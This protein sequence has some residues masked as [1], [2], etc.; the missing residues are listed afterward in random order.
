MVV[1]GRPGTMDSVRALCANPSGDSAQSDLESLLVQLDEHR[2]LCRTGHFPR[3]TD[4]P[5]QNRFAVDIRREPRSMCQPWRS[6]RLR[7]RNKSEEHT[8]ELQSHVN[9]VC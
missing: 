1:A 8:S 7:A 3:L 4:D 2:P 6:T 9:L 5:A